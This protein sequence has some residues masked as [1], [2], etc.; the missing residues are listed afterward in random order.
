MPSRSSPPVIEL[1]AQAS[2]IAQIEI[3]PRRVERW[4]QQGLVPDPSISYPGGGSDAVYPDRAAVQVAEIAKLLSAGEHLDEVAL[5]LFLRGFGV[6]EADVKRSFKA[7]ID[8]IRRQLTRGS[9][10][11]DTISVAEAATKT[12]MRAMRDAGELAIWRERVSG[13][14][15][16]A[17]AIVESGL[18]NLVHL[19]LAGEPITEEGLSEFAAASGLETLFG[20][21]SEVL[22][23]QVDLADIRDLFAQLD[24]AQY[25]RLVDEFS[26]K[27]LMRARE[28]LV[29]L[30]TVVLP[31]VLVSAARLDIEL[32][33][34]IAAIVENALLTLSTWGLPLL[35]WV[36][37]RQPTGTDE[38]MASVR[39]NAIQL[40]AASRLLE[41]LPR[42]FWHLL[43]PESEQA[44]TALS[45]D[46]RAELN[47]QIQRAFELDSRLAEIREQLS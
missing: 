46:E 1:A 6:A 27:E 25:A 23:E 21:L 32:P 24:L 9:A 42:R 11:E 10:D 12:L 34:N 43:G 37:R 26:L 30:G 38:V 3:T 22:G 2:S 29:E 40:E 39:A 8:R 7:H 14:G 20:Y 31:L 19:M 17:G 47:E 18:M 5:L 16:A 28:M 36:F 41:Y 13:R 44:L 45:D 15:E 4:G 33:D 35:A